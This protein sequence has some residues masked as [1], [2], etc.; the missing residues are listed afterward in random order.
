MT[1]G[2]TQ[3]LIGPS[4]EM[5][6]SKLKYFN[7]RQ[8]LRRSKRAAVNASPTLRRPKHPARKN[9]ASIAATRGCTLTFHG[10]RSSEKIASLLV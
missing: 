3:E 8:Q 6:A 5:I 10:I 2:A 7:E 1:R 9:V 4:C